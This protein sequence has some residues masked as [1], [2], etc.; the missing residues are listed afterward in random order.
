M[1]SLGRAG[2]LSCF[3]EPSNDRRCCI[4]RGHGQL[5]SAG[6][7]T[8][9]R[10]RSKSL[11]LNLHIGTLP[12]LRVGGTGHGQTALTR[13]GRGTDVRRSALGKKGSAGGE[14]GGYGDVSDL[15]VG[16]DEVLKATI[17][18]SKKALAAQ[19]SLLQQVACRPF[20]LPCFLKDSVALFGYP[21]H[22]KLNSIGCCLRQRKLPCHEQLP[23]YLLGASS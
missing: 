13:T 11:D 23:S 20:L 12:S 14:D 8:L 10:C 3:L 2:P 15:D 5:R 17:E 6:F 22:H 9:T 4:H 7:H 1:A 21:P 16:G 18:K 19:K